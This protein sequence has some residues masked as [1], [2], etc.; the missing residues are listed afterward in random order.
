MSIA[1]GALEELH[2]IHRQLTDVT[3]RIASGPKQIKAAEAAV[4]KAEADLVSAKDLYK[5]TRLGAD[6]KQLHLKQRESKLKDLQGKLNAAESN[7]EYQLL[8]EQIAA[9]EKANSVLTDEILEALE[10]LDKRQADVKSAETSLAKIKMELE[11]VKLR[12]SNLQQ[13]LESE[14]ARVRAELA[15]SEAQ[16]PEEFKVE[17]LRVTKARGED[18]LAAVENDSC[19][20]CSRM[21]TP[22][23]MNELHMQ[24][25]VFCK[26]CGCLLYLLPGE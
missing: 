7:R 8:K 13:T 15:N 11:R 16:L 12:V 22:Q 26:A 1:P 9:D 24:K 20:H 3:E 14:L 19:G 17:Y 2:R 25:P 18:A 10:N 4:A 5:K 21:L 23:T 6:E